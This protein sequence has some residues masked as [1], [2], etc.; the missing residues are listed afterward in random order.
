M[1]RKDG[2]LVE[3]SWTDAMAF[4]AEHLRK[5]GAELGTLVAPLSSSEEGFLLAQ[6]V[7]GLG[8]DDIDHRLRQSDFSDA[9]HA[10][11]FETPFADIEKADAVLLIGCN[12]RHEIPLLNHRLRKAVNAGA[13]VHVINPLDFD[14]NFKLAGKQIVAPGAMV[15]RL[16][17]LARAANDAGK[18]PASSALA[19]ELSRA[20]TS[21]SAQAII[22][23]LSESGAA[24]IILGESAVQHAEAAWLRTAARFIARATGA[25]YNEIPSGANAI[26]L[27]D[28][29]CLPQ[30]DGRAVAAMV[31][32]PPKTLVVYHAGS[33]DF[34]T[35]AAFD[36]ACAKAE[37]HLH[38][39]AYA[40]ENVRNTADAVLP[41][42]LPPEIDAS[43]TNIDGIVQSVAAGSKLPGEARQGWRVLR[44]L[45]SA[46]ALD[47]FGFTEISEVRER[48]GKAQ[49][50][51]A[52]PGER[53]AEPA[54]KGLFERIATTAI[55]RV[56]AVLRR[57]ESL[58]AHPLTR[59]AMVALN[60]ADAAVLGFGNGDQA[61]V[62]K[63]A[64]AVQLDAAVPEGAAWI[65][66]GYADV[67]K[68]PGHGALLRIARASA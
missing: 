18:L 2:K 14:F 58:N 16:L 54:Q 12:P 52:E 64:L 63:T 48:M 62:E 19:S 51:K 9:P 59:G 3:T 27:S 41:I 35:P 13:K 28:A 33:A 43:Y 50:A 32:N 6:L 45:G 46:L 30:K 38:I 56:D 57:S 68:L 49:A 31:A 7:R 15:D 47:G 4:V 5:A 10:S 66:A 21:E 36:Q 23:L 53:K 61:W 67:A 34:A 55:Y 25:G 24:A 37:F 44:A 20:E 60:P 26:G 1:I 11:A 42:G 17:T 8:S 40:G 65:E 22:K 29:G 39:G